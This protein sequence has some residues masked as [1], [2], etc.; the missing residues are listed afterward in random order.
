MVR[1]ANEMRNR[2]NCYTNINCE[3]IF[4]VSDE[5]KA[6]EYLDDAANDDANDYDDDNI[7]WCSEI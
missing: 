4:I 1:R 7:Q 5:S 3:H 2:I 6:L